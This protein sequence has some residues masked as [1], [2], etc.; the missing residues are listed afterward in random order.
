MKNWDIKTTCTPEYLLKNYGEEEVQL[1]D[2]LFNLMSVISLSD[3]IHQ[4]CGRELS[5]TKGILQ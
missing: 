2:D 5:Y 4:F 3:Y 1:Y